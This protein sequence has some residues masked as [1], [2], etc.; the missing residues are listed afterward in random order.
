MAARKPT[1]DQ[2][3]LALKSAQK[4][5]AITHLRAFESAKESRRTENWYTRNGGPNADIRTA[6][7]LL[8]RRHQDLV[9][10]NPWANRAIRVIVN[11]WVGDGIIGSPM[12]GTRRYADA[13][14]AW[15][16]TVECDFNGKLNWYGLQALIA[17][18]TAVRGS[19]LIRRRMDERMAD[20]GLVG[21]R[22][23]V[24]EPDMLDFSRDDGSRIRFG[25][26]YDRDGR[27]EGYW[28]RQ[29]HPGET[30]W[31]GVKIQSDFVPASEIIHTYEV[32]RPNQSIGVPF[33]SAVLL[34]LRDIDDIAQAMLLKTKIAA[35]FTAFVYS[36]EPSDLATTTALTETLEPGAIEIL[37]DGKQITFAN[38]PQSPDY[39]EHQKHHL[40]A[41]AAGYGVT[42]EA[43][44]G[45]LSD[46][47][48][49]SARMGWLEFHRNVAAWRWN[50]TVPQVLDPVHRW[51]N[52]AA[53]LAQLRGPRRMIWTPPR[54][55]LVDPA[56]E[57]RALI[58]GVKAGFMSLSEV[59]RSLGFIPSE[60]MEE[61]QADIADARA[62]GLALSVDGA[63]GQGQGGA[64]LAED[65]EELESEA[66]PRE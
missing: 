27:L 32:N 46:V 5:L 65:P 15:A 11:N 47:N 3:E 57:I 33:G 6:W 40:H 54:R 49:S 23:Q 28:L 43:L 53:R 10:S 62:K 59:Q 66:R 48:F 25:Q 26:Q 24:L 21:L 16:D 38:P 4:E 63:T 44:T 55:E 9:D 61:L 29:T 22:L 50:I 14:N 39:V 34:H 51:F 35:C 18:T 45:I 56:K 1:R 30:E 2:L 41:V 60:V 17:R 37:P 20:Q 36:N 7:S 64:G 8:T 52:D 58:E 19:C 13:W 42:F 31:N 12:G